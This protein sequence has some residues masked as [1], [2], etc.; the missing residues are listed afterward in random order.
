MRL[1]LVIPCYNEAKNLP[2]LLERCDQVLTGREVELILVDNGSTDESTAVLSKLLRSH[3]FA[4]S[5]RVA[6]NRGYGHG[7][8][9]G[10]RRATSPLL[11]WTHADMQ[12][13]PADV[14]KG[15]ELFD[16]SAD[17]QRLFVK[18]RRRGRPFA[19]VIFTVGMSA[20]ETALLG[21]ALWDINAQPTMFGRGFF[22]SWRMPPEDFSLDLYA[23]YQARRQRLTVKRVPVL[24]GARAHGVSH[25]NVNWRSKMKF[26]RRTLGYSF[27]L[28]RGLD[29]R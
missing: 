2:I 1:S 10:L 7:I 27:R 16:A 28:R 11:A 21:R 20:F 29:S 8:A 24:F 12:T 6:E 9:C 26:I 5:V 15:L 17:P 14:L 3:P 25:W 4:R 19:D 13:D 23:L 18:G 22:E